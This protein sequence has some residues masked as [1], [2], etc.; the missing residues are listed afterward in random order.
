MNA[1]IISIGDEL[2]IGQVVNTNASWLGEQ[3]FSLGIPVTRVIVVGDD[4]DAIVR[5][6]D[7]A[8]QR[9]PVVVV[10]GGL[11]PTHDDITKT[12]ACKYFKTEL[13]ENEAVLKHVTEIFGRR[14]QPL[15]PSNRSQALVPRNCTVLHNELGTAPGMYFETNGK[16]MFILPGVPA[17][18]KRIFT[19]E[20]TPILE[21]K[22]SGGV[23]LWRTLNTTGIAESL[24]YER[25]GS[26]DDILQ[27]KARLAFLPSFRGVRLRITVESENKEAAQ[28]IIEEVERRIREKAE[29]FIYSTG[30]ESLEEV[31]GKI[32]RERK[33]WLATAESCTGGLI[34]NYITNVSGSSDY[35]S[36][37]YVTYANEAK[38]ELLDVP[39]DVLSA[40]GAVSEE[41][42]K[43]MAL[44]ARLHAKADVA[45][46][47]TGIA[48]PL[49]GS[50]EKP[51]G[52]VW[53]G[54]S[55]ADRTIAKKFI[56]GKDRLIN[57]ERFAAA[58]FDL[59]RK[60]LLGI[61][62]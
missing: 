7:E 57:K 58:A 54:Y 44:G 16:N 45:I 40:H 34:A 10:T 53:I 4:E 55:D 51:I 29:Q 33:L 62:G 20:I 6:F 43:A 32:L 24:L 47:T 36:R 61:P 59:L 17:E 23:V 19:D 48:G 1:E 26:I 11:G 38:T 46:S 12:I 42:A 2:L 28:K 14:G 22:R 9:S 21:K 31:I 30:D 15:T 13:I 56:F 39:A 3:L 52:L 18:M 8:M 37:G 25:M 60:M 35:F 5:A 49:G 27:G 41:V 50:E